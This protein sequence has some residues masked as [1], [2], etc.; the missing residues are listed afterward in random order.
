MW[1]DH[2]I[3]D[4]DTG[5]AP[6]SGKMKNS[7]LLYYKSRENINS[8]RKT[9]VKTKLPWLEAQ[10]ELFH[11]AMPEKAKRIR[12]KLAG[13]AGT[14]LSRHS[15]A[16]SRPKG[17]WGHSQNNLE[18]P[19]SAMWRNT[20]PSIAI[21]DYIYCQLYWSIGKIHGRMSRDD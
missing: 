1:I 3:F 16:H 18:L 20:L 14:P 11:K 5:L 2:L 21:S 9:P 12:K 15:L 8:Y 17:P 13:Q 7:P 10:M 19:L 4:D 6:E